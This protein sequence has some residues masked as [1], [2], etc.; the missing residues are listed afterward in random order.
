MQPLYSLLVVDDEPWALLYMKE[1]LDRPDL[2]FHVLA[3]TRSAAEASRIMECDKPDVL[4]TDIRMPDVDG[5]GLIEHVRSLDMPCEVVIVSGF[6]EFSYAQQAVSLGAFEYCLKPLSQETAVRLLNRL[7]AQL[8]SHHVRL[9]P[10]PPTAL[11]DDNFEKMLQYIAE[12]HNQ[13]LYLR[14]LA[15]QFYITPN[16]CCSLFLKHKGMTFSQYVTQL[17]MQRA[18]VYLA[19]PNLSFQQIATMVGF[20]D[21]SYFV[22]VFKNTLDCTP[23]EYR[24]RMSDT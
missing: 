24:K 11:G 19:R 6:A 12:H 17:R 15:R 21:Y 8:Q 14:D 4:V 23:S 20:D 16:Y 10:D 5:I 2:G 1:L 7:R 9:E 22:K 13:R 18:L 3:A